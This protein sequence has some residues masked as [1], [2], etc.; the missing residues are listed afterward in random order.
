MGAIGDEY[1]AVRLLAECGRNKYTTLGA[2]GMHA[3]HDRTVNK[4]GVGC[5]A[6]GDETENR[7]YQRWMMRPSKKC[8]YLVPFLGTIGGEPLVAGLHV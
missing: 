5:A 3:M 8:A 4:K 1:N 7:G 2:T 6:S